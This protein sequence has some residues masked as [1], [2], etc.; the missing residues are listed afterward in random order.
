[1]SEGQHCL[2][3]LA[4]LQ[5]TEPTEGEG[6]RWEGPDTTLGARAPSV[7]ANR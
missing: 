3:E 4:R 7:C 1:M 5:L 2:L 6:C